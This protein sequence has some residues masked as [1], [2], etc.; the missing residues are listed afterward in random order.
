MP[1]QYFQNTK[2]VVN[3]FLMKQRHYVSFKTAWEVTDQLKKSDGLL[4][5]ISIFSNPINK[6]HFN[7]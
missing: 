3:F 5:M 1:A 4:L 6:M 7:L 2:I